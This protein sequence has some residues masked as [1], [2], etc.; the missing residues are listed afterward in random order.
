MD[1]SV[2]HKTIGCGLSHKHT[3]IVVPKYLNCSILLI[4]KFTTFL[5]CSLTRLFAISWTRRF[6]SASSLFNECPSI[7]S[8]HLCLE[9]HNGLFPSYSSEKYFEQIS[10]HSNIC[11]MPGPSNSPWFHQPNNNLV[12]STSN[13]ATNYAIFSIPLSFHPLS[14]LYPH[15]VSTLFSNTLCC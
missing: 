9:L 15:L 4:K 6:S 7:L 10:D 5:R 11:Y 14:L 12:K 2:C 1:P 8:S 13:E 3:K